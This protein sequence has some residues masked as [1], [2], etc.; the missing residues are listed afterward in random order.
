MRGQ[1]EVA[2]D[3]YSTA[4]NLVEDERASLKVEGSIANCDFLLAKDDDERD[5]AKAATQ[6]VVQECQSRE[7]GGSVLRIAQEN[8]AMMENRSTELI[9]YDTLQIKDPIS[10]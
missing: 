5:A 8:L 4:L 9:P 6:N 10:P 2:R 7:I 3:H 1:P